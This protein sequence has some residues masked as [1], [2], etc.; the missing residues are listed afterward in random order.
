MQHFIHQ[1]RVCGL[2]GHNIRRKGLS[3]VL[4]IQPLIDTP[5]SINHI[6]LALC[7][8]S[9]MCSATWKHVCD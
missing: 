6:V 5:D 2:Q 3:I 9:I 1:M 7:F 8:N 4:S